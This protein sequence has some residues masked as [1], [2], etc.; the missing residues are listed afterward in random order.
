MPYSIR[1]ASTS[2]TAAASRPDPDYVAIREQVQAACKSCHLAPGAAAGD[3]SYL[4]AYRGETMLAGGE[5]KFFPGYADAAEKIRDAVVAGRMPP[6]NVRRLNPQLYDYLGA[7]LNRWVAAGA[8]STSAEAEAPRLNASAPTT[9]GLMDAAAFT[10]IGD[11]V[12]E[13]GAAGLDVGRDLYFS[14]TASLPPK[15]SD[16]DLVTLD[17]LALAERGTFFYDVEYPLWSD[18]SN[19]ARHIHL[20]VTPTANGSFERDAVVY[21]SAAKAFRLPE[22]ARFYKTFFKARRTRSGE[23][24]N[25]PIETRLIVVRKA[26]RTPLFGTYVWNDEGTAGKTACL[27]SSSTTSTA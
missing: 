24:V 12:P 16:T 25:R 23:V 11:C 1:S 3:F 13:A 22:N 7:R 15:L 26:P 4:D 27:T 9:L 5:T 2:A 14:L 17:A 19:K 20:P 18:N 8:P 10:A 21:D 6:D